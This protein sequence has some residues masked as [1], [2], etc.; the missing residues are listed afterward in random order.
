[1]DLRRLRAGEWLVTAA[2]LALLVSLFLHWRSGTSGWQA[3]AIV[4]VVLAVTALFGLFCVAA[5]A[6]QPTVAVSISSQSVCV[7]VG[8]A[9]TV[10]ALVK[11]L[12][13]DVAGGA[14]LGLAGSL[15]I[16]IGSAIAIRDERLSPAG[17]HTDMTGKP[18]P[19]PPEIEAVPPPEGSR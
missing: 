9:A 13:D 4:D 17:R 10:I 1:M 14:F 18:V 2:S 8:L 11:A 6:T 16:F 5:A 3:F 19:P 15:G 12:G 7:L